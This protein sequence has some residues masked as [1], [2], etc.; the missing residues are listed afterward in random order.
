MRGTDPWGRRRREPEP[1]LPMAKKTYDS[2]APDRGLGSGEDLR[3][4]S[5]FDDAFNTTFISTIGKTCG[6]MVRFLQLQTVPFAPDLAS[7]NI[8][9][10]FSDPDSKRQ[11]KLLFESALSLGR[12]LPQAFHPVFALK[13]PTLLS[14][15]CYKICSISMSR[16]LFLA[17]GVGF[18][19][20]V[21]LLDVRYL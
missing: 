9:L 12:G 3:P 1:L 10:C 14:A 16:I 21:A 7:R 13:S 2:A 17:S 5:F 8:R 19:R 18:F 4:F 20:L 11:T 6:R 15:C